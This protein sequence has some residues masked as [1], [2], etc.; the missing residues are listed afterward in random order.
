MKDI[1]INMI[2]VKMAM[3]AV[4]ASDFLSLRREPYNF[5]EIAN[6]LLNDE[7]KSYES[8]NAVLALC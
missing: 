5:I 2:L 7:E 6:D 4:G 3:S 8:A 1:D